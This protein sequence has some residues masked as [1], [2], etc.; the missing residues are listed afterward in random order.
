MPCKAMAHSP[1]VIYP[2]MHRDQLQ[3][4]RKAKV[5]DLQRKPTEKATTGGKLEVSVPIFPLP[6]NYI[7]SVQF[8]VG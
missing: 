7:Y 8:A 2:H 6:M 4:S 5:M 1:Q 3:I